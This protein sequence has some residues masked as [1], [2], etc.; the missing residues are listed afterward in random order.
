MTRGAQMRL[1]V[2]HHDLGRLILRGQF[3]NGGGACSTLATLIPA[4]EQRLQRATG[5]PFQNKGR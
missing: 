1:R 4:A 2:D 3:G 5:A